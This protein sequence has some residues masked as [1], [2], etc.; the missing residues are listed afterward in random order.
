MTV[1][2]FHTR[3]QG[4]SDGR[5]QI[6]VKRITGHSRNARH[7]YS[8]PVSGVTHAHQY[9]VQLYLAEFIPAARI[10][11]TEYGIGDTGFWI[12]AEA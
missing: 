9:A 6:K 3:Y 12:V 11:A 7:T 1:I 8:V 10:V 5:T 2:I 4:E